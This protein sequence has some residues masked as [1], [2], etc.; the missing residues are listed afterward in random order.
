MFKSLILTSLTL[1]MHSQAIS[2]YQGSSEKDERTLPY[3]SRNIEGKPTDFAAKTK[4]KVVLVVNVASECGYTPQYAS[5][6]KLHE[7][8]AD[9]GLV[10]LGVPS[11][12]FG[13][14]EPGTNKEIRQFCTNRY[15]VT[16]DLVE[17]TSV[18]GDDQC[19]LYKKLTAK[20]AGPA[21]AGEVKWNFTK[22]LVDRSG[23]VIARFEPGVDPLDE[24][25][26]QAIEKALSVR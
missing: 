25:L 10:V 5:L 21:V 9:K 26:V 7:K 13:G 3:P 24:I 23:A 2:E 11:N 4:G 14:Q 19:A 8:F 16:F 18:K 20:E 1:A 12:E 6:Q 17:K 22:F 15:K